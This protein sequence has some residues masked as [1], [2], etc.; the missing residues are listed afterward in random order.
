MVMWIAAV[1][2]GALTVTTHSS[3]SGSNSMRESTCAAI[4]TTTLHKKLVRYDV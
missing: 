1:N 3:T 2:V 4:T